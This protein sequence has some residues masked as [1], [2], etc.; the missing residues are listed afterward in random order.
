[1]FDIANYLLLAALAALCL[2]PFVHVVAISL[3]NRGAVMGGLVG[4]WPVGFTT[5]NYQQVMQDPQF[6]TSFGNSVLRLLLG[7]TINLL[8]IVLTAYP[9]A[10][11]SGFRGKQV[12]KWMLIVALLF[13]GGLIPLY[14][15]IRNLQMLN[16]IWALVLPS[17]VQVFYVIVMMNFFRGLPRELSE[18]ALMDGASHWTILFRIFIPLS[19]PG[20]LTLGLFCAIFHWN[21]WFDGMVF[22]TQSKNH[23]LQTYLRTFIVGGN[24]TE[25]R[26]DPRLIAEL[27]NESL[28]GAQIVI[29]TLPILLVYPFLQ[30]HFVTG[31]TLGSVKG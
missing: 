6:I 14:L 19:I 13:N 10:L 26:N 23:P 29:A 7:T 4:I 1:L 17:A 24:M 22:I 5:A 8:I 30:K 31:L 9:L 2:F 20:L 28:R 15:V 12:F 27:S 11:E 21:S 18:A 3:S 25:F 16:T